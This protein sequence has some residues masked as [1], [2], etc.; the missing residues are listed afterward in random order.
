VYRKNSSSDK[1]SALIIKLSLHDSLKALES[2]L[3]SMSKRSKRSKEEKKNIVSF[4]QF[5]NW[6]ICP[7]RWWLDYPKGLRAFTDS[8]HTVFGTA[9]HDTIQLYLKTLYKKGEEQAE[10]INLKKYFKFAFN[11]EIKDKKIKVSDKEYTEF[12]FNGEDILKDFTKTKN[13]LKYFPLEKYELLDIEGEITV[14]IMNNVKILAYLDLVLKNKENDRIR[15]V[16]FKTSGQGW[17]VYQKEDYAK[18]SQVLVYKAVYSKKYDVPL[19]KIDVEFFILKRKLYEN[20]AWPQDRIQIFIPKNDAKEV[21]KSI[22]HFSTFV[23][24][25]FNADGSYNQN[26]K[27][28]KIP[29]KNRKNCKYC[30]HLKVNCDGLADPIS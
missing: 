8:I 16:D 4:S 2:L 9:I 18:F 20:V 12:Y 17:T 28:P 11:R 19:S 3:I 26:A 13:R 1:I 22:Y 24:E 30:P 14:D 6:Y 21:Q 7:N 25:C 27:H 10:K 5:Q 15:I 29:G 23:K